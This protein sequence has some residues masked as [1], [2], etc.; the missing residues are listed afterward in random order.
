VVQ[1]YLSQQRHEGTV[2]AIAERKF[3]FPNHENADLETLLNIPKHTISIG[4]SPSGEDLFPD[5]VVV[6]RPGQWLMMMA[7]VEMADTLTDEQVLTRWAPISTFG[8]LYVY[9][10][11]GLVQDAKKLAK[12]H[13]VRIAG[14]RTWRFR[15]VWGVD[16]TEA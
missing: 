15:P 9:V 1:K 6:R 11:A 3:P 12:K 16:V 2:A 10:P 8:D 5:I 14:F 4:K 7:E 13:G